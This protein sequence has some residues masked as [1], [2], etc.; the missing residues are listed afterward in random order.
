MKSKHSSR[1][2]M[3]S[4]QLTV[5]NVAKLARSDAAT[6][7]PDPCGQEKWRPGR[8]MART[9]RSSN[10]VEVDDLISFK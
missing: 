3:G 5:V 4:N 6:Q 10:S 8:E 1:S 9:E 2:D 7:P